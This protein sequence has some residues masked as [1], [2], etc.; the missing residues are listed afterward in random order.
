MKL[1]DMLNAPW[2]IRPERFA[3]MHDIYG[4]HLRSDRIPH[5]KMVGLLDMG[6][7]RKEEKERMRNVAIISITGV[8]V[9]A[10]GLFDRLFYDA[11]SMIEI[12]ENIREALEEPAVDALLL[13]VDSPG[14]TVDGTQELARFI[15]ESRGTKPIIAYTDGMIASAAYWIAA[16]ADEIV[17]SGDTVEIGSIGVAATH[18]DYSRA[19]D[20]VGITVSEIYAGK[21][22]R[23]VSENKPLNDEARQY[24]QEQVDQLYATFLED[25]ALLRGI[26]V[27]QAL[28]MADG[29]IYIG[30]KALDAGL[31]DRVST[32]DAA[33]TYLSENSLALICSPRVGEANLNKENTMDINLIQEK[34]PAV[35]EDIKALGVSDAKKD[36][37]D[38][39]AAAEGK[40]AQA[41][42]ERI[43]GVMEQTMPGHEKE[44]MDMAF[45][46]KTTGPEA[47]V[48]ILQ[49]EKAKLTHRAQ[50][51]EDDKVEPV[52]HDNAPAQA[53]AANDSLPLEDRC[54]QAWEKSKE[55]REEFKTYEA[56]LAFEKNSE[57]IR[58]KGGK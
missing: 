16:A 18:I 34:Y 22:K 40:G 8:L 37:S 27:E 54:K 50:A 42:R 58:I 44:I 12:R 25:V 10:P 6:M 41:E 26:T 56:Y 48:K 7:V 15:Y 9:K 14:G 46:G 51:L 38:Q 55:L 43:K 36:I 33:I 5:D 1:I 19:D 20:R 57:H 35:F 21:Y 47:A 45:D 32:M 28:A 23:M 13:Y 29:K 24:L 53:A 31:V 17:I 3:A 2:A 11:N 52:K 30:K 39:L 49:A 4:A